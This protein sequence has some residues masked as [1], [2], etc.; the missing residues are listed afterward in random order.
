MS[1]AI[2]V[3]ASQNLLEQYGCGPIRFSGDSDALYERHLLFDNV[4]D[5][6]AAR[7]R[8]KFDAAA[9]SIR[10]VL[11]QRWVHTERTYDQQNPKRVYYLSMEFLIGRSMANNVTN[12]LVDPLARHAAKT[13]GIDWIELL[14]Q[15]PDA[16]LGNGGLG[17]LAACFLDSMATLQLPAMGYGLR[18][19][20][21]IFRQLLKDG[22]QNEQPDNWLRQPDPWEVARV[23]EAVEIKLNCSFE[24][25][26]G[27]LRA[28]PDHPSS[29]IGIP[30]DRP[31]VGYGGKTINTMPLWAAA[32]PDCFDF[33]RFSTGDFVGALAETLSA[34]SLTRVLYPDDSTAMGKGLR[35]VQEY[36]LVAC[37]LA[38]L[39]RRFRAGNEDWDAL[40]AKVAIQL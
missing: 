24:L 26:G 4:I 1:Q 10:D 23:N 14:E 22:W 2:K 30:Y 21:G 16:G 20:Y 25:H 5:P 18:Y 40:P 3:A 11:S 15:E 29:L 38:D 7:E 13:K 12:L 17:R 31:V 27:I 39:L 33:H 28:I 36:F 6:K 35:F 19:E 34:E 37:S 9:R 8:E 32:A